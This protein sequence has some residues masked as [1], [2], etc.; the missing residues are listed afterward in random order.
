MEK[1]YHL[2]IG[3]TKS[4]PFTIEE[5]KDQKITDKYMAW[6][7]GM[8]E[9]KPVTE[10][11]DVKELVTLTPPL[12]PLS[13]REIRLKQ[14]DKILGDALKE[15]IWEFLIIGIFAFLLAGG[16]YTDDHL[17]ELYPS[18]GVNAI[19]AS[20]NEIRYSIIAPFAGIISSFITAIIILFRYIYLNKRSKLK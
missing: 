15:G 9:W 17:K 10:V 19:Y 7:E 3:K 11:A 8:A 1:K 12:P 16:F 14:K 13:P 4:G 5:L 18:S 20:P 6:F 2:L